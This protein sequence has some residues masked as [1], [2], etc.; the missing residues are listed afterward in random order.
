MNTQASSQLGSKVSSLDNLLSSSRSSSVDNMSARGTNPGVALNEPKVREKQDSGV[1]SPASPVSVKKKK[2]HFD[3]KLSQSTPHLST[4]CNP[5]TSGVD[6]TL[7]TSLGKFLARD[8]E[9]RSFKS[10]SDLDLSSIYNNPLSV[11]IKEIPEPRSPVWK[12]PLSSVIAETK[13]LGVKSS[14]QVDVASHRQTPPQSIVQTDRSTPTLESNQI[15]LSREDLKKIVSESAE[16]L[17][18]KQNQK[19]QEC[20]LSYIPVQYPP[21]T[22]VSP[23]FYHNNPVILTPVPPMHYHVEYPP[24]RHQYLTTAEVHSCQSTQ[25]SLSFEEFCRQSKKSPESMPTT[26]TSKI[27]VSV[28][29]FTKSDSVDKIQ[30]SNTS[31]SHVDLATGL[32]PPETNSYRTNLQHFGYKPVSFSTK[33]MADQ[34]ISSGESETRT[35]RIVSPSEPNIYQSRPVSVVAEEHREPISREEEFYSL[36]SDSTPEPSLPPPVNYSTL[37][38]SFPSASWQD[39]FDNTPPLQL[40]DPSSSMESALSIDPIVGSRAPS[41]RPIKVGILLLM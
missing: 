15:S 35:E 34:G 22:M 2:V 17:E 9:N 8:I 1:K 37:P 32:N 3:S 13:D 30:R 36:P 23:Y 26:K 31:S 11:K 10:K 5:S 20:T 25:T 24:P 16:L 12:E 27:P 21:Y 39:I 40:P 6:K 14:A 19:T 28:N 41:A 38:R 29:K 18:C 7:A 33:A 4:K